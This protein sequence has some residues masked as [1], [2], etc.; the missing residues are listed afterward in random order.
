[1]AFTWRLYQEGIILVDVTQKLN[2][3]YNSVTQMLWEPLDSQKSLLL[4]LFCN[5][6]L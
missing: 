6:W 5:D 2:E 1:M 4:V 3:V